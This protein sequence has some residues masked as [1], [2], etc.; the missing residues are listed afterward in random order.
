M[1][2]LLKIRY[3]LEKVPPIII[4]NGHFPIVKKDIN[5]S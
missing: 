3:F 4:F 2:E 1:K 5:D